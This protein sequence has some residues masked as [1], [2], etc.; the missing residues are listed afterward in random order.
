MASNSTYSLNEAH[1]SNGS[2]GMSIDRLSS[3][4]TG[5]IANINLAEAKENNPSRSGSKREKGGF[6]GVLNNF[7]GAAKDMITFKGD[8]EASSQ[9]QM[10]AVAISGPYNPV[11]VTHVGYNQDTGEFTGLPPDW[12]ALLSSSGITKQEQSAHPQTVLDIIGFYQDATKDSA[13]GGGGPWTKF[14][15]GERDS[16]DSVRTFMRA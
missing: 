5:G 12:Q 11:H 9:N 16:Y 4:S 7:V 14:R 2:F 3:G 1:D 13:T 15:Y 8:K 10:K 6:K